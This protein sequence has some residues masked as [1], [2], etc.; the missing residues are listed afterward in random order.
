[1]QREQTVGT[2]PKGKRN[3]TFGEVM[4]LNHSLRGEE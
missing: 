1:M 3:E 4:L 2:K